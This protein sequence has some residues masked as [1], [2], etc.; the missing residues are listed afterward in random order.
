MMRHRSK[1]MR[2]FTLIE[3]MVVIA[4][5]SI[6]AGIAALSVDLIR[7]EQV[8]SRTKELLADIQQARVEAMTV[9]PTTTIQQMRGAGIRLVSPTSFVVFKFNDC[10]QDYTY[11]VD[12]CPGPAR[13]EAEAR[14]VALP[15]SIEAKRLDASNVLVDPAN[16][17]ATDILI[18]DRLG[19]PRT[20][21]WNRVSGFTIVVR[22]QSA[23][24]AKCIII[25]SNSI[26]EGS[27]NGST[28]TCTRQ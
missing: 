18:F 5:I 7:K 14:T 15:S 23:G 26:R 17:T 3:L 4:I 24:H 8:S 20:Y 1:K 25:D 22:H 10:D 28:N 27:W 2:G 16:V 19:M 9:G 6:L 13:E 21:E 11:D 12:G